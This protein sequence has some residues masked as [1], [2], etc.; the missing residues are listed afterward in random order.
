M[1]VWI[2]RA[3][4]PSPIIP[5]TTVRIGDGIGKGLR[6]PVLS[7]KS[8]QFQFQL[9]LQQRNEEKK[10]QNVTISYTNSSSGGDTASA[11][12]ELE[13]NEIRESCKMWKWKGQYSINYLVSSTPNSHPN[14]PPLFLVHGFGASI[15]HWRRLARQ[16]C[17]FLL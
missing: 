17:S 14:S 6:V 5:A 4:V 7:N 13:V 16:V 9:Q 8:W 3:W 15:P 11:A 2:V 10:R 12:L 1:S